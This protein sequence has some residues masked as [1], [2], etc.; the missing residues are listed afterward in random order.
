MKY[1]ILR[2]SS[3]TG[4]DAEIQCGFSTPLSVISNQPAYTQSMM[5]LKYKTNSQNAQRWEIE[6][7]LETTNNSPDF[8]VHSVT[9]GHANRIYVRMPQVYG[10]F[11]QDINAGTSSV[12]N[13]K[14]AGI[15]TIDITGSI[16]NVGEFIQ[17]TGASKVYLVIAKTTSDIRIAPSLITTVAAATVLLRGGRVTMQAYYDPSVKLG[18]TYIDGVLSDPG[19]VKLIEDI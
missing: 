5:N 9:A 3:N 8:L 19:S 6:A 12:T 17:F 10:A 2:S 4:A 18:I 16:P 1:G 7:N 11:S 13:T 14:V 15:D